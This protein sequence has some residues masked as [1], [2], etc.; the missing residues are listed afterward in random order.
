MNGPFPMQMHDTKTVLPE[1]MSALLHEL[2]HSPEGAAVV[3]RAIKRMTFSGTPPRKTPLGTKPKP[4]PDKGWFR[5][6]DPVHLSHLG[7]LHCQRRLLEGHTNREVAKEM[8][9]TAAAVSYHRRKLE[10]AKKLNKKSAWRAIAG[11][12]GVARG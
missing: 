11:R 1:F 2:S 12:K 5:P 7:E 3:Q 6:N 4:T 10:A 9:I 8:G